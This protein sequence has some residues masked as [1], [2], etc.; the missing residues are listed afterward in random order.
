MMTTISSVPW[1]VIEGTPA[2]LQRRRDTDDGLVCAGH[3]V[4]AGHV[5]ANRYRGDL[6]SHQQGE[7]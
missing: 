2:P 4:P 6:V 7:D 5:T 1:I 3:V